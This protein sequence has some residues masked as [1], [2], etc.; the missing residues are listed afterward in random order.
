VKYGIYLKFTGM[1]LVLFC[2]HVEE[3]ASGS[4]EGSS[5]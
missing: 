5:Q 4:E 2:L 3:L 1:C